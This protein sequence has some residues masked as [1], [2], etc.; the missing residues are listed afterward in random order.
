MDEESFDPDA[1]P[2]PDVEIASA[3][4][5]DVDIALNQIRT[6]NDDFVSTKKNSCWNLLEHDVFPREN[7]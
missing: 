5:L 4:V 1:P 3:A 2:M 7:L 6:Y